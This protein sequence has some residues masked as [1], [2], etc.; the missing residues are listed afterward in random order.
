MARP[1]CLPQ[2]FNTNLL[3]SRQQATLAAQTVLPRKEVPTGVSLMV[4]AQAL[5]GTI[6]IAIAQSL[7]DNRLIALLPHIDG[8]NPESVV[9]QGATQLRSSFPKEYLPEVLQVYNKCLTEV[10]Y[11][12]AAFACLS[13]LGAASMEWRSMKDKNA[14][15]EKEKVSKEREERMTLAKQEK[16]NKHDVSPQAWGE[17]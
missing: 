2:G 6:A 12:V 10:Y 16:R 14:E 5:G 4:F 8:F 9:R 13:L 1:P 7:L 3:R 17:R 11:L 15:K